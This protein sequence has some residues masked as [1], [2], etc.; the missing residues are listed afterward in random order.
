M[1]NQKKSDSPELPNIP[2]L[3]QEQLNRLLAADWLETIAKMMRKGAVTGF[4]IAW[5][6]RYQKPVGK[7]EMA[8]FELT[9]PLE[10]KLMR[11]IQEAKASAERQVPYYDMTEEIKNHAKCENPA[12]MA[13]NNPN[14]A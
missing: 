10:A 4:D 5:D 11:D 1:S 14:K 2:D 12:C 9:A 6:E 13:C 3:S 8:S 7:V